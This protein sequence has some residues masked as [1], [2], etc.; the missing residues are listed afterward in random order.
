MTADEVVR[1]ITRRSWEFGVAVLMVNKPHVMVDTSPCGGYFTEEGDVPMLVVA[2]GCSEDQWLGTLLHEYSHLTQWAEKAPVWSSNDTLYSDYQEW[3]NGKK[4]APAIVR[5]AVAAAREVEA[6]CERRTIRLIRELSAP[7][8]LPRYTRIANC[9]IHFHNVMAK[10]R[11]WFAA[12]K[13]LYAMPSV[14]G[15]ANAIF[16]EDFSKTPKPLY[17]ALLTCI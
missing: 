16:D 1:E 17:D 3:L 11:K 6:D 2:T 8:D 15:L 10:T 7:I 5:K 13:R 12:D 9:Y 14:Y 4:K